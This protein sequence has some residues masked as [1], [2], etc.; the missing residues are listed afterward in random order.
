MFD[1]AALTGGELDLANAVSADCRLGET[2]RTKPY[3]DTRLPG[4][5]RFR[6]S[7]PERMRATDELSLGHRLE[8][9]Q[10]AL[11][12]RYIRPNTNN[13]IGFLTFDIDRPYAGLAWDE[14]NVAA[15]NAVAVN[16]DNGHA[17]LIYQLAAPISTSANSRI[18]PQ[19]Y[20]DAISRG[21]TRRLGA[22]PGFRNYL[23]KNPLHPHWRTWWG[24]S[25][26]Y[27]LFDL[28]VFLEPEDMRIVRH[29]RDTE[30]AEAGR[31]CWLTS[32]LAKYGLRTAWRHRESGMTFEGFSRFMAEKAFELNQTFDEPLGTNEVLGI[33]RSVAKWAWRNSTAAAFSEIQRN[34]ARTRRRRNEQTLS[35]TPNRSEKTSGEVAEILHCSKRN[36]RRIQAVPRAQYEANSLSRLKPWEALEISRSTYYRRKAAGLL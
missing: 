18:G 36:A 13:R 20:L 1:D 29:A 34:R 4:R 11:T 16:P 9:R 19:V 3:Q 31:N 7:T 12:R 32:N 5:D 14:A 6:L 27:V 23:I 22:D 17:H 15:P 33:V 8:P 24:Q 35:S 2:G 30:F 21:M 28:A 26:A 10:L 25:Q